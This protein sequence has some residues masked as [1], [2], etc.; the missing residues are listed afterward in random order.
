MLLL[1]SERRR[2]RLHDASQRLASPVSSR[3][4]SIAARAKPVLVPVVPL[5]E[6][7]ERNSKDCSMNTRLRPGTALG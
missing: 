5:R 3:D 6:S 2:E 1:S 4:D 7:T